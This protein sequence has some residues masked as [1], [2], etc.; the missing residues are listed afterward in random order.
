MVDKVFL[1]KVDNV[2]LKVSAAPHVKQE[3]SEYFTFFLEGAQFSPKFR[4]RQWDG[5]I[6]LLNV[7]TGM[8]YFGLLAQV[9][10]FCK[11]RNYEVHF[12]NDFLPE[13]KY[14]S[15]EIYEI[16]EHFKTSLKPRDYQ[17]RAVAD[18]LNYKRA[19]LKSPTASGKSFIIYLI[20]RELIEKENVR[21]LIIVPTISLIY[22]MKKDFINYNGNSED[23]LPSIH[24]IRD[25]VKNSKAD[26]TITT[27]Q[28]IMRQPKKWFEQFN[29]IIGDEVHIFDSKSLK[30]I[31]EKTPN[32]EYKFGLTG[33]LKG[34]KTNKLTLEGLFGP[35]IEVISTHELIENKTLADFKVNALILNYSR[36]TCKLVYDK[37]KTYPKEAEF[38]C[39]HQKRN[40]FIKNLA[41]SLKGNTLILFQFVDKHGDVLNPMLQSIEDKKIY[42]IHG[43]TS[44]EYREKVRELTEQSNDNIIQA[45][46]GTFQA[47]INIVNLDN[48]ILAFPS[49][50]RVRILQSLGR[51]LRKSKTGNRATLYDIA[52]N[53][54]Y[55]DRQ[56]HTAKQFQ[57]RMEL[58]R[59]EKHKVKIYNINLEGN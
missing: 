42:Y 29:T 9:M 16:A 11:A 23:G 18:A 20:L 15:D 49:K 7:M 8:I 44:A 22:Q 32:C 14:T 54:S 1:E 10:H 53:L 37:Y 5:K 46:Y 17:T 38:I 47:G 59:E 19:I 2:Y 28:S 43:E 40:E 56:N 31:M 51:I 4:N 12:K 33:S 21:A 36:E 34:T 13:E 55:G 24:L 26:I 58:Y 41:K 30:S 27:Y 52:D 45:S 6:R 35:I 39:S 57:E 3:M 50:S 48:L 25:G